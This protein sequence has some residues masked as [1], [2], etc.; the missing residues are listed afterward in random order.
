MVLYHYRET[1]S[2]ITIVIMGKLF[3]FSVLHKSKNWATSAFLVF[4]IR[5]SVQITSFGRYF[6]DPPTALDN[7]PQNSNSC[8]WLALPIRL[9]ESLHVG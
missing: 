8:L 4:T 2:I 5:N 7:V 3:F 9:N 6:R 1:F